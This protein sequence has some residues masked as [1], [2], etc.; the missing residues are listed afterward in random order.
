ME[1][2]N[3]FPKSLI[4]DLPE[5]I[6]SR[7]RIEKVLGRGGMGTV[8]LAT[9]LS[10]DRLVALKVINPE[11]AANTDI[12]QR[13]A[14]EARLMAKLRHPR[15][16]MIYDTGILPDGHSFIVMEYVEGKTLAQVIAEQ[17]P[18]PYQSAV[19]IA[20]SICDVLGEAHSLGIIHRDLKPANIML[21]QKGVFVLDFGIAKMLESEKEENLGFSM[22]GT[23]VIVGSPYYMSPEQ[24]LGQP[25][26]ARSDLYSL[27]VL[28]FEALTGNPPFTDK[29]IS[30]VI[31][32][33]ATAEPPS[34]NEAGVN[35]PPALVTAVNRLLAKK[36]E[37]R[38][39]TAADARAMLLSSISEQAAAQTNIMSFANTLSDSKATQ[40]LKTSPKPQATPHLTEPS[41]PAGN[42]R[43]LYAGIASAILLV[44]VLG[45]SAAV[46]LAMNRN[47]KPTGIATANK[48]QANASTNSMP[49]MA[50]DM[51]MGEDFVSNIKPDEKT[52][53]KSIPILT[54]EEADVVITKITQTTEHRADGMQIVK[55]P[56]DTA[57][58]CLHNMIEMG[59]THAFAVERPNVNS[60]WAISARLSLDTS[61]FHGANWTFE[62]QDVD[63]DGFEEVIFS[64]PNADNTARRVVIY[65]P[66]TRQ[67]YTIL[68]ETNPA[69][70]SVKTTL[71]PN[72]LTPN[73]TA[74]R[75]A[76]E[77]SAQIS[78]N[79]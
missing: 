8:Y 13:F 69:D 75:T 76:L 55:T 5:T 64:S 32:K 15:A 23:G 68:R 78:A 11:V 49:Q 53:T 41:R 58:V 20:A 79:K 24:C 67:N 25:V 33:H 14:R 27:G 34:L 74:F 3:G 38:P 36:L 35:V 47:A 63:K 72:S 43:F 26:E 30:A 9:H 28:L 37:D 62:P 21:N 31:I 16:A 71:S 57:L 1:D 40:N 29:T 42:N 4:S 61:E 7:F 70:K 22:T 54:T 17:G 45:I 66:R 59:K 12:N 60:A 6:T 39:A 73:A 50:H 2:I 10:L 77:Q 51:P 52:D 56:N 18:L 44:A 46:W 65:V 19:E 48:Q